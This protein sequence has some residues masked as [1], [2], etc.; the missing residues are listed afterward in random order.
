MNSGKLNL[1][2]YR[3]NLNLSHMHTHSHTR[4]EQPPFALANLICYFKKVGVGGGGVMGE[5]QK[6]WEQ[7]IANQNRRGMEWAMF[8]SPSPTPPFF[9]L[10]K[11]I[12]WV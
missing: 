3:Y 1:Q 7:D 12:G 4:T 10:K 5:F 2:L 11:E 9:F 6:L 8:N